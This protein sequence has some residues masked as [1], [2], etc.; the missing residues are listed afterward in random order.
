VHNMARSLDTTID[1]TPA[2]DA[3]PDRMPADNASI[4]SLRLA[5]LPV[6]ML[7]LSLFLANF[8]GVLACLV[9]AVLWMVAL[10]TVVW[11]AISALLNAYTS[12]TPKLVRRRA[13][14]SLIISGVTLVLTFIF[15]TALAVALQQLQ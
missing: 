6:L 4:W 15:M 1:N 12:D 9:G 7:L 2:E 5:L 8:L 3:K 10:V 13:T 14:V 11:L